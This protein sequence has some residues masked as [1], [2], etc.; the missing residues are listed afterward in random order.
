M[1]LP[2]DEQDFTPGLPGEMPNLSEKSSNMIRLFCFVLFL[3]TLSL[4]QTGAEEEAA[5]APIRQ[6]FDGMRAGDSSMVRQAFYPGA[7]LQSVFTGR[8]GAPQLSESS[9]DEF[10]AAVGAPHDEQWDERIWSYDIR[11]D[12]RLAT[13]WTEY[14]FFLGSRLLH[15][16]VN[17]FHLFKSEEGW[18]ITHITDT[19]RRD[20]C[21]AEAPDE[22]AAIHQV[23]DNWHR[24]AATADAEAFFGAMAPD[25]IYLGTDATERWLRD[26]LR[27]WSKTYFDRGK[28]WDFTPSD[29]QLYFSEDG[30]TAWF[31]EKLATWMG[32][33]RGS[34]VLTKGPEGW[35]ISHYNL[36]VLVP[37]D[38]IQGVIELLKK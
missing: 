22:A 38:K 35:K 4:A 33:C 26:E 19:R 3:P 29:R 2:W 12:G 25:G 31:E 18:K 24:A 27:E 28:A 32:P 1:R 7:R 10:A 16:G 37:N 30:R 13:A 6:L 11:I 15:C 21:R 36:A 5:Y 14:S 20:G 34:G 8:D 9:V 23:L 17:A